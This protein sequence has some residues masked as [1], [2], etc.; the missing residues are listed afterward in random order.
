MIIESSKEFKH[1]PSSWG[2]TYDDTC[3]PPKPTTTLLV[4]VFLIPLMKFVAVSPHMVTLTYKSRIKKNL[5][6][7]MLFT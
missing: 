7:Y 5:N 1:T 6:I 4:M 2:L 3:T